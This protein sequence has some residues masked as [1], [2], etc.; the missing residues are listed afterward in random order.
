MK[1]ILDAQDL[2][3]RLHSLYR[4]RELLEFAHSLESFDQQVVA[5]WTEWLK[6]QPRWPGSPGSIQEQLNAFD[7]AEF[8]KGC[9]ELDHGY[10]RE[11]AE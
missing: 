8:N 2:H 9:W 5:I 11:V 4:N 6:Y 10:D 1:S 7:T 3:S